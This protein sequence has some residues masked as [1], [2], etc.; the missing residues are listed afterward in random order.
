MG[1]KTIL[2][3][4]DGL[5]MLTEKLGYVGWTEYK[6]VFLIQNNLI[7]G[8]C[9]P[10]EYI[11]YNKNSG[12]YIK[13]LGALIYLSDNKNYPYVILFSDTTLNSI[14][15]LNVDNSKYFKIKLPKNR[16]NTTLNK[17]GEMFPEQLFM[18]GN[19][20]TKNGILQLNYRFQKDEKEDKWYDAK[21]SIHIRKYS[22]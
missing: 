20:D 13:N 17:T 9:D 6:N 10:P 16:I 11:V 21:I 4:L 22:N 18:D 8:C 1:I 12:K 19:I 3:T 15:L 5:V 7:S 2:Y 14:T